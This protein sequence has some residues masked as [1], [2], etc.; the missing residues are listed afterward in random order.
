[1]WPFTV[2]PRERIEDSVSP[3]ESRFFFIQR[4]GEPKAWLN[5]VQIRIHRAPR[6]V[7]RRIG[8][9]LSGW[10]I[11]APGRPAGRGALKSKPRIA[12][13]NASVRG[14]SKSL[15]QPQIQCQL[16]AS[17]SS[18]PADR[19][20]SKRDGRRGPRVDMIT[21][22]RSSSRSAW[23]QMPLPW[24]ESPLLGSWLVAAPGKVEIA[25]R[26]ARLQ[27]VSNDRNAPRRPSSGYGPPI[28]F[29][30]LPVRLFTS[31]PRP[32][33]PVSH[34]SRKLIA[35]RSEIGKTS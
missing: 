32:I 28:N 19:I 15:P 7:V 12:V 2:P 22:R 5:I 13:C 23:T 10:G 18:H 8:T 30:T 25:L 34:L 33:N 27:I 17:P 6:V 11:A 29:V 31:S 21:G 16:F 1:V 14:R 20:R 26:V 24:N 4:I 9:V 35:F 3:R